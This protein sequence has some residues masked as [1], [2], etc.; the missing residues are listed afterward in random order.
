V[1]NGE[2]ELQTNLRVKKKDAEKN[3]RFLR[4]RRRF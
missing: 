4:P 2:E 3:G 1:N